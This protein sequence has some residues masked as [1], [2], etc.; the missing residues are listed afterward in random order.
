MSRYQFT[1]A[2]RAQVAREIGFD[3]AGRH[4]RRVSGATVQDCGPHA[5]VEITL[6]TYAHVLP[7]MQRQAAATMGVLLHG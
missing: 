2:E 5:R 3:L 6:N 1:D 7:D 4:L